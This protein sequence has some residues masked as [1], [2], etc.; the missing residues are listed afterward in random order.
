MPRINV[1]DPAFYVDPWEA[2]RWLRDEAPVYW[3]PVQKLWAISRYD[4]IMAVERDGVRYSFSGFA[5]PHRPVLRS[6]HD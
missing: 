4:D 2:F 5:A 6:I 1:L 3:D